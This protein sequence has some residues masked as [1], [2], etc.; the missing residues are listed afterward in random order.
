MKIKNYTTAAALML[1]AGLSQAGTYAFIPWAS[2]ADLAFIGSTAHTHAAEITTTGTLGTVT[3]AGGT[4]INGVDFDALEGAAGF[5]APATWTNPSLSLTGGDWA[6]SGSAI[7]SGSGVTGLAST[8]LATGITAGT[9]VTIQLNGLTANTDYTFYYFSPRWNG[10]GRTGTL[11][12][13]FDN[14][15]SIEDTSVNFSQDTS[16]A[17]QVVAYTYNT[18]SNT[19][20]HIRTNSD[21]A[22]N[23][24]HTYG[25]YKCSSCP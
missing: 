10:P 8:S 17:D 14:F 3:A 20:L 19:S 22:G 13:S 1:S 7:G 15:A 16:S 2:D 23:T 24:F 5:N 9:G 21:N 6:F 11:S 25:F 12:S 4:S 18:G